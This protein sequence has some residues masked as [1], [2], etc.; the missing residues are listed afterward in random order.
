MS[1]K[2]LIFRACWLTLKTRISLLSLKASHILLQTA[3]YL[4]HYHEIC[5]NTVVSHGVLPTRTL[6]KNL[7]KKEKRCFLDDKSSKSIFFRQ[8]IALKPSKTRFTYDFTFRKQY[9]NKTKSSKKIMKFQFLEL[10]IQ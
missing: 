10:R 1:S 3:T 5:N 8:Q 2:S 9:G 7:T 6:E 4:A